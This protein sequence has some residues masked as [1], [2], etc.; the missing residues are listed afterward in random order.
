MK[1]VYIA[2]GSLIWEYEQLKVKEWI[3]TNLELPVEFSRVS[4]DGKGRLTLVI[5]SEYGTKNYVW[6]GFSKHSDLNKA[7]QSLKK[8]ERTKISWIGF[9]NKKTGKKRGKNIP[10]DLLE[11]INDWLNESNYDAV[12]WTDIPSNWKEVMKTDFTKENAY[13]YFIN[14]NIQTR[15]M[16]LEYIHK[17]TTISKI[18]TKFSLYFL[19]KLESL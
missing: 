2:W 4:D 7:I 17:A 3:Q 13:G 6:S 5:D 1:I 19:D 8:R 16:I 12:I 11:K 10:N 15:Y 18:Q 14:S 9:I